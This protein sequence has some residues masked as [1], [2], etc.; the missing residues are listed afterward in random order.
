MSR[1]PLL[2]PDEWL[3]EQPEDFREALASISRRRSLRAGTT[4]YRREDWG[5]IYGVHSGCLEINV[6]FACSSLTGLHFAYPGYFIGNRPITVGVPYAVTA[7]ARLDCEIDVMSFPDI[8]QLVRENPEWWRSFST[9]TDHW[10]DVAVCSG[11][12]LMLR[13]SEA[14]CVAVLL[15]LGG[16]RPFV[17]MS[18]TPRFVPVTQME[19]A[20]NANLSRTT[21]SEILGSLEDAGLIDRSYGGIEIL[22]P[23]RLQE[24]ME[25]LVD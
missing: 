22:Q 15:R 1:S 13:S 12:D 6:Q 5:G 21:V 18:T 16:Y 10:F 8:S 24:R 9:I 25:C 14:R 3:D 7:T 20:E 4:L 23:V 2:R 11:V 17:T 19:L